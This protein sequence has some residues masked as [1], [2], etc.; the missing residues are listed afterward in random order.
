MSLSFANTIIMNIL[1]GLK[2]PVSHPSSV[3]LMI[4]LFLTWISSQSKVVM[5]GHC[6]PIQIEMCKSMRWNM[7]S[8]PNLLS[9]NTQQNAILSIEPW[10]EL[11]DTRCSDVLLFF[12]CAMYAPICTLHFSEPVPPCKSVCQTAKSGCEPIMNQYDV[13]WPSSL[14]CEMLQEYDRGV[15]V[16]PD[17]IISSV[18]DEGK[19]MSSFEYFYIV[20]LIFQ[21]A[22]VYV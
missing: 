15:C 10:K 7:T 4:L 19:E 6:E 9:H 3:A 5:G 12:L 16:S 2:L 21:L 22:I 14:D 11:L 18:P 17:A 1:C 8:M 13:S 20:I